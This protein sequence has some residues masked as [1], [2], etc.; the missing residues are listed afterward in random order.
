MADARQLAQSE[1]H[2]VP[3]APR[4]SVSSINGAKAARMTFSPRI[5]RIPLG[6]LQEAEG[7]PVSA[8][9]SFVSLGIR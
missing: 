5:F 4:R 1:Y 8:I 6:E 9:D 7:Q 2:F 3:L